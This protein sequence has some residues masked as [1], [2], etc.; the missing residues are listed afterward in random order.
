ML[1]IH[2][3]LEHR[4][5]YRYDRPVRLSPHV[6]RLR[7]APHARPTVRD[8][9]QEVAPSDHSVS[10]HQDLFGNHVARYV[11]G[12]PAQ[13]LSIRVTLRAD[14]TPVNPFDFLLEPQVASWPAGYEPA[15]ASSLLPFLATD[16]PTPAFHEFLAEARA[17]AA[18]GRSTTDVLMDVNR[19]VRATVAYDQRLDPGVQTPPE[20]LEQ[21]SGSCRDS[22]WLLVH[23]LR[24]LGMAARF[25]S[26]YLLQLAEEDTHV[27]DAP[28]QDDSHGRSAPTEDTADL[29]AWAE[30]YLPGAGWLG[31]D[32]TSG[33]LTGEGHVPLASAT[34]PALA[35]PVS[36]TTE[37][38]EVDFTYSSTLTRE[39]SPGPVG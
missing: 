5:T 29:H 12:G 8:H 10:W 2:V 7:P 33:L 9:H 11:F 22:S 25:T 14:L 39:G 3:A 18:D 27:P 16:H 19:L 24:H 21:R 15:V 13:E 23:V 30:V 1:A 32:P 38:A 31:L 35:A 4:T 37:P 34:E 26:G 36:G 20:T 17:L 28:P 6:V